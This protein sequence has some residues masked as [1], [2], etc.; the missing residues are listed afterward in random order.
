[1]KASSIYRSNFHTA[2]DLDGNEVEATVDKV[3][4]EEFTN[5]G[6]KV[7]KPVIH[8]RDSE[9]RPW[10]VN[11]SNWKLLATALGNETDDWAGATVLLEPTLVQFKG[12][13]TESTGVKRATPA[14]KAATK[15]KRKAK[16]LSDEM[17]DEVG[18]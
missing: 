15:A 17:G 18:F 4:M 1:M 9:L 5:D 12:K 6:E 8:W 13:V 16:P 11:K 2:A 3:V 10:V 7:R 14:P